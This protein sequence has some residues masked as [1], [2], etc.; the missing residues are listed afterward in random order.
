MNDNELLSRLKRIAPQLMHMQDGSDYEQYCCGFCG[1]ESHFTHDVH[2]EPDCL[3]L[4]LVQRP[5]SK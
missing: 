2:H 5:D 4:V 3:G 1:G